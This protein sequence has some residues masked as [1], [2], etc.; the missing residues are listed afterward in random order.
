MDF[1]PPLFE[2]NPKISMLNFHQPD[3]SSPLKIVI[4]VQIYLNKRSFLKKS[5]WYF[6]LVQ[7]INFMTPCK[8]YGIISIAHFYAKGPPNFGIMILSRGAPAKMGWVMGSIEFWNGCSKKYLRWI[9]I[10]SSLIGRLLAKFIY[11]YINI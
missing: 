1:S 8:C 2:I 7:K 9:V 6:S 3:L 11:T 10:W 4:I 5:I